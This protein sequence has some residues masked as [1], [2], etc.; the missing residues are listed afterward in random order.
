MQPATA[1][2]GRPRQCL[3]RGAAARTL[4]VAQQ[5]Q[6]QH[7]KQHQKQH[8]KQHQKQHRKQQ[9]CRCQPP[10]RHCRHYAWQRCSLCYSLRCF[11]RYSVCDSCCL[12]QRRARA[13]CRPPAPGNRSAVRTFAESS[14]PAFPAER[15]Q[16]RTWHPGP[17][18]P[19]VAILRIRV[20]PGVGMLIMLVMPGLGML[21]MRV[22]PG[23]VLP[24]V[25][26]PG[27]VIP[28]LG[29]GVPDLVLGILLRE[30]LLFC[31][32]C[33]CYCCCYAQRLLRG[34]LYGR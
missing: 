21:L 29:V 15:A 20:I 30:V 33:C 17:V 2:A 9:L 22:V 14:L 31:C 23:V 5:Y 16:A 3:Q 27:L 7:R 18:I 19:G 12:G 1:Q 34:G 24:E 4:L 25:V 32:R 10:R 26:I 28:G 11:V 13:G 8:R 6:K